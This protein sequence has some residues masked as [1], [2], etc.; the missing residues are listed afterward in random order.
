M[1]YGG[2]TFWSDGHLACR[3]SGCEHVFGHDRLRPASPL[4]ARRRR[5]RPRGARRRARSRW[6]PEPGREQLIGEASPAAEAYGVRAGLRLGEALARCPTPAPRRRPTRSGVADAWDRAAGRAG[7]HRRGGRV[8]RI[9]AT[10]A[11]TR[12]GSAPARRPSAAARRRTCSPRRPGAALGVAGPRIGQPAPSR[13]ARWRRLARPRAAAERAPEGAG[14][15][16]RLH[17]AA[18]GR[19]AAPPARRPRRSPSRS[20]ASGSRTLGEL[21]ALPRA[22]L[23]DRFGAAG[24]ARP[25]PRPRAG[26][27]AAPAPA[28]R[29]PRGGARAARVGIG[30]AARAARWGCSS[31]ACSPAASGAGAR[32]ARVVLS[33]RLVEGGTWRERVVFREALADPRRMRLVLVAAPRAAA[34]ARRR[35]CGCASRRFGP[36]ARRPALAV[37]RAGR[38]AR[39]RACARRCARRARS[40]GPD[41]ALR[42]LE[43]D[44]DSRVPERRARADALGS[45]MARARGEPRP[46]RLAS[47]VPCACA[48]ATAGRPDGRRRAHGRGRAR[49][50]GWSRIAGG[51]TAR[52][53]GATGRS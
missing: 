41:A 20:S 45:V 10:R 43:V 12:A 32:C 8:R 4:R 29:A 11:S 6:R 37:R 1:R 27:P 26:H 44:P 39:R 40:P 49:V 7:G 34:G 48:R 5:R 18:A 28:R 36:P 46:R 35:R 15:A 50:A 22:A 23:A 19:A 33:A 52:C 14:A 38:R 24:P 25:R 21:A 51:P 16:G 31:T 42:I 9:P 13:F 17:G 3:R 47:R 53:A 2:R 30:R